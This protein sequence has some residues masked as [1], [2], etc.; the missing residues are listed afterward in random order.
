[1]AHPKKL[2]RAISPVC[3]SLRRLFYCNLKS[4][5]IIDRVPSVT[6]KCEIRWQ[7][8]ESFKVDLTSPAVMVTGNRERES[9]RESEGERKRESD[10]EREI[11]F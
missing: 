11:V 3:Q 4:S 7:M 6:R 9:E 8:K 5:L 10:R 1:M 2:P